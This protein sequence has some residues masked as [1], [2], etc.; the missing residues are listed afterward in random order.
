MSE[1][2]ECPFCGQPGE[3]HRQDITGPYD[4]EVKYAYYPGCETEHC[5]GEWGG[6]LYDTLHGAEAIWNTRATDA[7]IA[8][9]LAA[10][11]IVPARMEEMAETNF[12]AG[13]PAMWQM[14]RDH[15]HGARELAERIR[16]IIA[17][18]AE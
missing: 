9:I 6:S 18:E 11:E 17:G 2:R 15:A 8:A 3:M 7:T 14:Y 10:C 12:D 16:R 4:R 5:P 13:N 1:L